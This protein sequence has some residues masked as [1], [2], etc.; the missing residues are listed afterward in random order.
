MI[1][2]PEMLGTWRESEDGGREEVLPELCP[3]LRCFKG[4]LTSTEGPPY[5]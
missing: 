3:R 1:L 5:A 4:E 2:G